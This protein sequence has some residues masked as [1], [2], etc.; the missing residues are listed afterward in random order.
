MLQVVSGS[1][2][3]Q[4]SQCSDDETTSKPTIEPIAELKRSAGNSSVIPDDL[5]TNKLFDTSESESETDV[6]LQINQ[7][8][9]NQVKHTIRFQILT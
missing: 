3:D 6:K 4:S 1:E 8:F 9:L 5:K 7:K 2:A